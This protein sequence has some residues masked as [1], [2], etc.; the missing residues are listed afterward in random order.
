MFAKQY[1]PWALIAGGSDGIGAAFARELA[2][3]GIKLMLIARRPGPLA[4]MA[5]ELRATHPDIEVRTLSLDLAREEAIERVEEAT[6][7]IEV[8]SL[9]YN[10]GSES[11]YGAFLDHDWGLLRGRL[12]RNFL[13]KAALV[14]HFGRHMRVRKRGGIILMGS[15]AGFAGSPGFALYASSK[16][17]THNLSEA[18]WYEFKKDN[19]HLLCTIVGP[20]N[21]PTMIN[22][23][24]PM[25]GHTTEP[26]FIARGA[27]DRIDRGPIWVAEDVAEGV[28]A[29][30]AMKP[31]D[32]ATLMAQKAAEFAKR[33]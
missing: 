21:T 2:G 25:E 11:K 17:F 16:A 28:A 32:R 1:G 5:A 13:V 24:G 30:C 19:V 8:G 9:I 20:T 4:E 18:L 15:T 29:I 14:H 6:A 26:A 22:A 27:L 3:R 23:Y 31:A 12:Q 10:A 7:D 33:A